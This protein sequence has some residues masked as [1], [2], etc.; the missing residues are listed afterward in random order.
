MSQDV[1]AIWREEFKN[2]PIT[3][4]NDWAQNIGDTIEARVTNKLQLAPPFGGPPTRFT[5]QKGLFVSAI[6]NLQ[7]VTDP[8]SG[9]TAIANAWLNSVLASQMT[10]LG[11]NFVGAPSPA[12]T[13][14]AP[15]IITIDPPSAA[16]AHATLLQ[17]LLNLEPVSEAP[18]NFPNLFFAAFGALTFTATGINSLP[19][20]TGPLPLVSPL[21]PVI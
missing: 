7:P 5:W 9:R 1:L 19:P 14:G 13:F 8:V 4:E 2:L 3:K 18:G 11:G 16:A 20:P 10:S 15:P 6:E 12:T 17:G 21:T